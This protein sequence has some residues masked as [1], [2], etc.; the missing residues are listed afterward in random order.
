MKAP[1]GRP[2]ELEPRMTPR[3]GEAIHLSA[4]L[5]FSPRILHDLHACG[6]DFGTSN[7][8]VGWSRLTFGARSF[9]AEDGK[10]TRCRPFF[11]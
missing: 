11:P 10:T 8:T 1:N 3:P 6:V 7:S 9:F 4:V 2:D 5:L